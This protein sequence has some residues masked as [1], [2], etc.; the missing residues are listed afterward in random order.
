MTQFEKD[1][2]GWERLFMSGREAA[3]KGIVLDGNQHPQAKA[4]NAFE[5]EIIAMR[6]AA[7]A[8]QPEKALPA[9]AVKV[10]DDGLWL[11]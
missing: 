4:G 7:P 9:N 3:R 8:V 5:F 11:V 10:S 2:K 1:F 6:Q